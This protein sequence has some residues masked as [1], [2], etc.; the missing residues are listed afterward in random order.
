MDSIYH[1]TG[2]RTRH[3]PNRSLSR[4]DDNLTAPAAQ[5]CVQC[6]AHLRH[7][8]NRRDERRRDHRQPCDPADPPSYRE[9]GSG[10][11]QAEGGN[12]MCRRAR[13]RPRLRRLIL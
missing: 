13:R 10:G 7:V 11:M 3:G 6:A 12:L 9:S 5:R 8:G 4:G 2:R 1:Q